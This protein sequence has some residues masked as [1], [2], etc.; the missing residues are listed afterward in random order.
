[1]RSARV[2]EALCPL[3]SSVGAE[4]KTIVNIKQTFSL[5]RSVRTRPPGMSKKDGEAG[6]MR[7]GGGREEK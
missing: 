3:D 2:G 4:S 1:M 6:V 5:L 7:G